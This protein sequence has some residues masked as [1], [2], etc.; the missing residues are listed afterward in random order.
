M[1]FIV[2]C[3]LTDRQMKTGDAK[4]NYLINCFLEII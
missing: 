2:S 3:Q 1:I 4:K